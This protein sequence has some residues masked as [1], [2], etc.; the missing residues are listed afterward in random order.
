MIC[1][2]IEAHLLPDGTNIQNAISWFQ[3]VF[4]K[5]AVETTVSDICIM[6]EHSLGRDKNQ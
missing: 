3:V 5:N 6:I 1:R 2:Y 4:A